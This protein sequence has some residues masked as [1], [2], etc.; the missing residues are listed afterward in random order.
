MSRGRL[1]RRFG[2]TRP[3]VAALPSARMSPERGV[4][5]WGDLLFAPWRSWRAGS[6]FWGHTACGRCAPSGTYVPGGGWG[7]VGDFAPW[8]ALRAGLAFGGHPAFGPRVS[9]ER[10]IVAG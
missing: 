7:C 5:A 10:F 8:R 4:A 2:D 9:P 3:A 1:V 6:A